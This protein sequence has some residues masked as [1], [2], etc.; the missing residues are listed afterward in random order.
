MSFKR[1]FIRNKQAFDDESN[2]NYRRR[3]D[4]VSY[5]Y[6]TDSR[7]TSPA[8]FGNLYSTGEWGV[9]YQKGHVKKH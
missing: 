9:R 7:G 3:Q 4:I 1:K 2:A 5:Q 6:M 8:H